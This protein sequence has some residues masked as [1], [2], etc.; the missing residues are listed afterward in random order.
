MKF[1]IGDIYDTASNERERELSLILGDRDREKLAEIEDALERIENG[2][3]WICDE[4]GEKLF[5]RDDDKPE[6]IQKR[7]EIYH[8]NTEPIFFQ[9]EK[10]GILRR[11]NGEQKI[12]DVY[13]EILRA[14][15]INQ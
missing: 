1:E 13:K 7:L 14:L 11:V 12:A 8:K 9:Y 5:V 10:K 2:N 4:C 3:Y 15:G 6:A